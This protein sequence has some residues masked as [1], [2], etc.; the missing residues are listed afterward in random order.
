MTRFIGPPRSQ[1]PL[2]TPPTM[3]PRHAVQQPA[4][5]LSTAPIHSVTW[6]W[7]LLLGACLSA[8]PLRSATPVGT[9]FLYQGHMDDDGQPATGLFEFRFQLLDAAVGG[10]V[11]GPTLTNAQVEVVQ[12]VFQTVLDFGPD[13]FAGEARWLEIAARTQGS[14]ADFQILT[15]RPPITAIPY[16]LFALNAPPGPPGPTGP[17]GPPGPPAPHQPLFLD[18]QPNR[19]AD[20]DTRVYQL[21]DPVADLWLCYRFRVSQDQR[22][23]GLRAFSDVRYARRLSAQTWEFA[24]PARLTATLNNG[25][26]SSVRIL[27]PGLGYARVPEI[28]FD[29]QGGT[30]AN[31]A[32]A[33]GVL[34]AQGR[35]VAVSLLDGGSGYAGT[36]ISVW[37]RD[38]ENISIM[39]GGESDIVWIEAT[40]ANRQSADFPDQRV[41]DTFIGGVGH[42][43]EH[44]R[45]NGGASD[46]SL[47]LILVDGRPVPAGISGRYPARRIQ[48]LQASA[49]YRSR[50]PLELPG[51]ATPWNLQTKEWTF[52]P[53]PTLE[54]RVVAKLEKPFTG[55]IYAPLLALQ[56]LY[57]EGWRDSDQRRFT[58]PADIQGGV[59]PNPTTGANRLLFWSQT[60]GSAEVTVH[61]L[62]A[63]LAGTPAEGTVLPVSGH[64][65]AIRVLGGYHKIYFLRQGPASQVNGR[66]W[67]R[68]EAGTTVSTGYTLR[69]VR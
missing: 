67:G 61:P 35:L 6:L 10:S 51:T 27:S 55:A 32:R 21:M 33:V 34:D 39:E 56:T 12:G 53:E 17:P 52:G 16:A 18:I 59:V 22:S 46:T 58:M 30:V 20:S 40:D 63:R 37:A 5:L 54:M 29:H 42:G 14:T 50:N 69:F 23:K 15:P 28:V 36:S 66:T 8:L 9:E 49:V 38:P 24:E 11:I 65:L 31:P 62:A 47:P 48:I 68:W 4:T 3:N 60:G 7:V 45:P 1:T 41:V 43:N 13:A 25:Q 64:E 2:A 44:P 57:T 19:N 26:V